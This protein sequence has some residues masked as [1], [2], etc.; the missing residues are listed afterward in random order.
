[1]Q[2]RRLNERKCRRGAAIV[3]FSVALPLIVLFFLGAI[4]AGRAV[5]VAHSMQEAAQAG[6][7]VYSVRDTT[8]QD[9][10]NMVDACM[11]DAGIQGYGVAF[12]PANKAE[13]DVHM[14]PVTVTVSVPY[15]AVAWTG[16][17]FMSGA[18]ITGRGVYPADLEDDVNPNPSLDPL[19]DDHVADGN[20]RDDDGESGGGDD[21]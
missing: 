12:D 4:E 14:E 10:R 11:A 9:A 15:S 19:D 5:M 16:A 6:A 17:T 8:W 2:I 7:R 13:I 18:N 1:M 21:D 3:E 20:F